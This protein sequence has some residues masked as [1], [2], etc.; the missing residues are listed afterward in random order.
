MTDPNGKGKTK[1]P[2]SDK[3]IKE[4]LK[5][6]RDNFIEQIKKIIRKK[7]EDAKKKEG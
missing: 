7:S 5:P 3:E 4:R 1:P 6:I 2:L